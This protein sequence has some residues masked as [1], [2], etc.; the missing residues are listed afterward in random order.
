MPDLH[1]GKCM[2]YRAV[3]QEGLMKSLITSP[4]YHQTTN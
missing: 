1:S 2:T 3:G 4:V